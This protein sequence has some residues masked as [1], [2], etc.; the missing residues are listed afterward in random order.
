MTHSVGIDVSCD[1][2]H[3]AVYA[4]QGVIGRERFANSWD[5]VEALVAWCAKR[6]VSLEQAWFV[7]ENTGV[8]SAVV[9]Y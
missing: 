3:V 7:V 5:G 6:G 1:T 9:C 2:L 4:Q 8:Y